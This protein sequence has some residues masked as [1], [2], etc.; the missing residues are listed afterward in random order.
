MF[1]PDIGAAY[2]EQRG[3][4]PYK[5][6]VKGSDFK[7]VSAFFGHA[8][9]YCGEEFSDG[10]PPCQDHLVPINKTRLGLH[11]WGNIVPSCRSCNAAKHGG[12]WKEFIL[13]RAAKGIKPQD[14]HK[15]IKQFIAEYRYN[16]TGD[17]ATLAQDLYSEVGAVAMK[18]VDLKVERAREAME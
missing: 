9:C 6:G 16:P 10:T 5:S 11:A 12:D 15:R 4:P 18:L 2:D 14:Q 1:L 8:C 7:V 13:E 3:Y 17:L